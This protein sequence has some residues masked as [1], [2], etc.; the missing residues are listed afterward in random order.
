MIEFS[1][2]VP[3]YNAEETLDLCLQSL[4]KLEYPSS[5][6]EVILVDNNS[7][8]GSAAIA[9]ESGFRCLREVDYQSSYAARNTGI[10]ASKGTFIAFTDADCIVDP[11]WLTAFHEQVHKDSAGCFAGEILPYEPGSLIERFS[12]RI[13]LLRQKGPLS[14]WHFKPFAQTANAVYRRKV[15]DEI[16]YFDPQL[17][18]GG[19]AVL[20]WKMLDS[21]SYGIEFV[22]D[23]IIHHK[24]RTDIDSLWEQFRKYGTAKARWRDAQKK[25]VPPV[26][27]E[28]ERN[29]LAQATQAIEQLQSAKLDE[30]K[31]ID[32]VLKIVT[33]A[34]HL[35]GYLQELL[36]RATG[37]SDLTSAVNEA[38]NKPTHGQQGGEVNFWRSISQRIRGDR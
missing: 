28:L 9:R 6:Y 29:I 18:S 36:L 24:H 38:L 7:T 35:N 23:A 27:T 17:K 32:P 37:T 1:I 15:L 4:K 12:A 31:H 8:D 25:F 34:A 30:S 14:G 11:K 10:R 13:G 16:G 19:D 26:V 22:P 3:F 2:V 20:S 33:Q 5:Q 21:T